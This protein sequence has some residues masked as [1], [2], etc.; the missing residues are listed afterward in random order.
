MITYP[1]FRVRV[2]LMVQVPYLCSAQILFKSGNKH[3]NGRD[4]WEIGMAQRKNMTVHL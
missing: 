4:D 1:E 3:G 2:P